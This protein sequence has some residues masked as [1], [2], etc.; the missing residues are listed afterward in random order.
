MAGVSS[1]FIISNFV[2]ILKKTA[3]HDVNQVKFLNIL[4]LVLSKVPYL[5]QESFPYI[6]FIGAILVFQ[7]LS[8]K[9][10]YTIL[11][12]CGLSFWQFIT[13]FVFTGFILGLF[14][15]TII[16]PISA[17]LLNYYNKEHSKILG[18]NQISFSFSDGKIW[19][20]DKSIDPHSKRFLNSQSLSFDSMTFNNVYFVTLNQNFELLN[21]ISANS[22][23]LET[24]SWHMKGVTIFEPRK[25]PE[26]KENLNMPTL[27][28]AED[29][30]NNFLDP[31]AISIWEIPYLIIQLNKSGYSSLKHTSYLYKLINKPIMICF[32]ILVAASFSL[33][34]GRNT[35][36]SMIIA[37]GIFLALLTFLIAEFAFISSANG[38]IES[39]TAMIFSNITLFSIAITSLYYSDEI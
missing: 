12:S 5:V 11:K 15:V 4:L 24:E 26:Y 28:S 25:R 32:L 29:I 16:N 8:K 22:A 30:Q 2:D 1:V 14:I 37:K 33:K 27:L 9:N 6:V 34:A 10:E 13:P 35:K 21:K 7:K 39:Y 38:T 19:L 31:E 36:T 3:R 23:T 20:V 17:S 18:N